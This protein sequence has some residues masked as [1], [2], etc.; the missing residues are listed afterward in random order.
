MA[1]VFNSKIY[2]WLFVSY[3]IKYIHR[4]PMDMGEWN[5]IIRPIDVDHAH[6]AFSRYYHGGWVDKDDEKV[7]KYLRSIGM[8]E[9][10]PD[11]DPDGRVYAKATRFG[12][13]LW[14]P[15]PSVAAGIQ[16]S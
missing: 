3:L 10:G 16:N 8:M 4:G 1:A 6:D 12:R 13:S 7:V 11:R 9:I 15:D 14:Y 2:I 5:D